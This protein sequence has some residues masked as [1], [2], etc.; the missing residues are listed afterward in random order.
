MATVQILSKFIENIENKYN[1]SRE[2]LEKLIPIM[3]EKKKKK[4]NTM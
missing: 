4:V 3:I 1:I 2:E